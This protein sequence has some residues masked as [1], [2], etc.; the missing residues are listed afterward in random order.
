MNDWDHIERVLRADSL[1][2]VAAAASAYAR[3]LGFQHYGYAAKRMTPDGD[4]YR[5]FHDFD[6]EWGASYEALRRTEVER[7]DAR[8]LQARAGLPA[9]AWNARGEISYTRADIGRRARRLLQIAGEFGL[10]TGITVPCPAPGTRWAF[11]TFTTD[12]LHDVRE[13]LPAVAASNYFAGCVQATMNRLLRPSDATPQLSRR[14]RDALAW[15]AHGKTAWE[16]S[17]ILGISE[18]T[19]N[20]HLQRAT[21]RLGA[22]NLKAAIA[23]AV[24][25]GL[26][27]P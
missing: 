16:I 13:M 21:R 17:T 5:Y 19:A 15:A 20:F 11:M 26:V 23:R 6:S 22:P 27:V 2:E 4:D 8:V 3:R 25:L 7:D 9:A 18:R 1:D 10:R 14:E 12:G 24:A